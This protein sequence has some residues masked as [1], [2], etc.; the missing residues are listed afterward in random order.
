[1]GIAF[2]PVY[3]NFLGID[4]YGLIGIY[5]S[6]QAL[7]GLLD[8]GLSTTLNR[9]LARLSGQTD[10]VGEMRDLVR[11][12]ESIYWII[13]IVIAIVVILLAPLIANH[14]V[15]PGDLSTAIIEQAVMVMGLT[16]SFQLIFTFY[17]GGLLG[18]QRQV[19]LNIIIIVI[20]T[21][22]FAGVILVLWLVSPTIQ[23]FFIWQTLIG[24]LAAI[25]SAYFLWQNLPPFNQPARFQINLLRKIRQFAAGMSGITFLALILTQLDK[26]ILSKMLT[27]E[28]FGYYTL[29]SVVAMSLYRLTSPIFNAAYPKFTQLVSIGDQL[30]LPKL[31]HRMCQIMSVIIIPPALII[32]FFAPEI[33]L[34][35]TRNPLTVEY[36][37]TVLSLLVIGTALNGLMNLPYALQLAYGWTKLA[38][39][40][41]LIAVIILVP[42]L[43]FMTMSYGPEG[44]ASAWIILNC[45]YILISIHFMHKRL[46]PQEKWRWYIYDLGCLLGASL[47]SSMF[48]ALLCWNNTSAWV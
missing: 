2:I 28:N 9:E 35:W 33:L 23:A 47:L 14:W 22:K 25:L 27:L 20:T 31:Y 8:I 41:N 3:I 4:S 44:A 32:A 1:M 38:F 21:L 29:A 16:I 19:L 34:L 7:F 13:G 39:Y 11:T 12:L 24:V 18:L 30:E 6:L 36:T 40:T 10:K 42:S 17:S 48:W 37:H 46:L 15:Q 45:G 43:I 26:I 5:A